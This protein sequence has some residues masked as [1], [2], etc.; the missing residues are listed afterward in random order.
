MAVKAERLG[1]LSTIV[2]FLLAGVMY[3]FARW[4]G[5]VGPLVC[6]AFLSLAVF[7]AA[8]AYFHLR[9]VR[10]KVEEGLEDAELREKEDSSLFVAPPEE[11]LEAFTA[12]HALSQF[13]RYLVPGF[14]I[15]F[16]AL[17]LFLGF[18][19]MPGLKDASGISGEKSPA[20]LALLASVAFVLFVSGKIQAA[21]AGERDYRLLIAP[22]GYQLLCAAIALL[23]A[24]AAIVTHFKHDRTVQLDTLAAW[25]GIVVLLLLGVEY[26]V[27]AV[28][29]IYR[30]RIGAEARA[31]YESRLG[32]LLA[33]PRSLFQSIAQAVD[34][35]FGF[36]VSE[37]WF[38]QLVERAVL[39]LV[40]A[41]LLGLYLLSCFAFVGPDE[42]G[43]RE[44]FGRPSPQTL[45]SG[46]H[47]KFPWPIDKVRKL[48]GK[49][50]LRVE[51]GHGAH[52]D[53]G[54]EEHSADERVLLWTQSHGHEND[55][56]LMASR[57][58]TV[59]PDGESPAQ[60]GT[61][62]TAKPVQAASSPPAPTSSA[63]SAAPAAVPVNLV[64]IH[65]VVQYHITDVYRYAYGFADA[66][67]LLSNLAHRLTLKRLVA[68]DLFDLMGDKR[69]TI[70][71]DIRAALQKSAD[72]IDRGRGLG[73][74]V[75]FVGLE[76][77]H[78]PMQVAASFQDV[79]GALEQKETSLQTARAYQNESV[80]KADSER[81]RRIADAKGYQADKELVAQG[82]AQAFVNQLAAYHAGGKVYRYRAYLDH[83]ERSLESNRKYLV[84]T[85][86]SR[87]VTILNLED[88]LRPDLLDL[89]A[90]TPAKE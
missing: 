16:A 84:T 90:A 43:I 76:N 52:E 88:K 66:Q 68:T 49:Q 35:Q 60:P 17:H 38:Y 45:S 59:E 81:A 71:D 72:A 4:S 15:L 67:E 50:A 11:N 3:G 12:E 85:K 30:P 26:L 44:R 21:I 77:V 31:L 34:Y 7:L 14:T 46:A 75:D 62:T 80:P 10:R 56:W 13:E 70:A 25:I 86:D 69:L 32:E 39:P 2:T 64:A 22:A 5:G 89:S 54:E 55:F 42:V 37:T 41:Q 74:G 18:V 58:T 1:L 28:L 8:F 9:L 19:L 82:E 33:R 53:T 57:E 40:G 63:G 47:L 6:A 79:I 24:L 65:A 23:N 51:I 87:H 36:Q 73:V 29:E 83:L 78:P 61:P 27:T 48:P 20:L